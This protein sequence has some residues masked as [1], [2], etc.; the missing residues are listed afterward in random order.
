MSTTYNEFRHASPVERIVGQELQPWKRATTAK[1]L[2]IE[3]RLSALEAATAPRVNNRIP[4]PA[5]NNRIPPPGGARLIDGGRGR[6]RSKR[7]HRTRR[8]R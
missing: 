7:R 5:V 8:H 3:A 6:R 1:L 4:V 2:E